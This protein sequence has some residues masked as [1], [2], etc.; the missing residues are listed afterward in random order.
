[1][2]LPRNSIESGYMGKHGARI[3]TKWKGGVTGEDGTP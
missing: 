2:G 3:Y 1:M